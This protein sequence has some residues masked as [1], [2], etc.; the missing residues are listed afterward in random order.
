[1]SDKVVFIT[2]ASSGI[3][4][5]TALEFSKSGFHVVGTARRLDRLEQLKSQK[6]NSLSHKCMVAIQHLE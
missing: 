2:G 1:M 5:A 4:Y 6:G 3:G